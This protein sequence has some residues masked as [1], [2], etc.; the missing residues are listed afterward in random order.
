MHGSMHLTFIKPQFELCQHCFSYTWENAI[1]LMTQRII[2]L[3]KKK[4]E[5]KKRGLREESPLLVIVKSLV[6]RQL[7]SSSRKIYQNESI[8][9]NPI[10]FPTLII[11]I[12]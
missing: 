6:T 7:L 2:L 10:T 9:A 3:K 8:V 11:S 5:R 12:Y 1:A 4:K